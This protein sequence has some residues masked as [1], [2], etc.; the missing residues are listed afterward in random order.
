TVITDRNSTE[1]YRV[2]TE[3]DRT[4]VSGASIPD[5]LKKA[6]IAIEDQRFYE[7][8]CLDVRALF[9]VFLRFGQA[10][11]ASTLT[12]QLA[13]NALDLKRENLV[14]RKFKELIL[15]CELESQHSKDELL[16]L[17]LNWI[18]FGQ[19]AYGIEQASRVY[20]ATSASGLTLAQSAVL[21]ALP[22]RPSYFSPYGS[23]LRTTVT[24][25]VEADVLRGRITT[26][27]QISENDTTI[28]LLGAFIGTGSTTL[29]VGGRTDQVLR[30]MQE[31]GFITEQERLKAL[32]E[33]DT[34]KFQPAREDIR[35]P[36]FVLWVRDQA[37]QLLGATAEKGILEQGGLTIQTTL[38]WKLQEVAEK[39]VANHQQDILDRFGAHNIAL[40][41]LEPKTREILAYVGNT[42]YADEKDGGKIDMVQVPRQPGSSFKP[43]VYAAAFQQGYSPATILYD[44]QTKIGEDEPRDFDGTFKGLMTIR[45][46]L[47]ASRNIPAAKAFFLAGG[48]EPILTLASALGAVT[49]LQHRTEL[50]NGKPEGFDYGWPLALGA[51]E[52][53][54]LEMTQAYSAFADGGM[55]KPVVS[56]LRI[57]DRKGNLLYA[58]DEERPGQQAIDPR[59]A[60]QITSVLSDVSVRPN[61]YWKSQLSVSGYE[62]AAKTGTSNKCLE[63]ENEKTCKLRKP[64]NAW[65]LGYTP[66]LVAGAWS[67]NADSSSLF[68]KGD[69]LNTTSPIWKEFMERAH[70]LLPQGATK[71]PV[72][73]GI[74][75]PQVSLLSG[76]LP[77]PCTPVALRKA[78]VFLAERAPTE[79]D[80]ACAQLM[81]D[82]VT[83]LLASDACPKEAQESG[84][85][86]VAHSILPERW[87][88]WEEGVQKWVSEQMALW[89]ATPDHSGSILPLP[90]APTEECDPALTPGRL[91]K[92]TLTVLTPE[93]NGNVN[94]PAFRPKIAYT[95]GSSVR[96]VRYQIDGK[97]VALA[98]TAPFDPPIRVP[99]SLDE[100]GLH[101]LTVTLVDEYYN[102]ATETVRF[103][104]GEGGGEGGS[105]AGSLS[106]RFT[107]PVGDVT[108][109]QGGPVPMKAEVE[110][111]DGM[112]KYVQFYL[113]DTLLTTKPKEPFVLTYDMRVS[114]G[115]YTLRAVAT[116]LNGKTAEDSVTVT[117]EPL[118]QE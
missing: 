118:V 102:E 5:H 6:V 7:R 91:T 93:E 110:D 115:T 73:E 23:H 47:G 2:F 100:S 82:K 72:P 77:T 103:R 16:E 76:E 31:Q 53:P 30:N 33:I 51:A 107:S 41:A 10:G 81:V 56:I 37:E 89:Y 59:I 97:R 86:L 104:F 65:V 34:L 46:A 43:I 20:F 70:K 78:E 112:L 95:V 75:T 111:P 94:Y 49:P 12:R 45:Q 85:F 64:D 117:V 63:W 109:Q 40:V 60:Y 90:V 29:Y 22:Q 48:E 92:P 58:A 88:T 8:G 9:R 55:V 42:D 96:E 26:A 67:G 11:G 15:G 74:V 66:V 105:T 57:T 21:A 17:Y 84:S 3:E 83:H 35:A 113:G 98:L 116:D 44:V 68:E 69:G 87:P 19:N 80:P 27:S 108:V 61:D 1:L 52:T 99:R 101:T 39:V 24:K 36:H 4:Y 18:P 14:N 71:F 25:E 13:R 38:D 79:Q 54:L 28:G 62:T 32:A 106:V 50:R 114:P